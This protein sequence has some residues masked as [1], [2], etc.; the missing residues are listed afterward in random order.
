MYDIE[1][2]SF[3]LVEEMLKFKNYYNIF[4]IIVIIRVKIIK[5]IINSLIMK[6]GVWV[7]SRKGNNYVYLNINN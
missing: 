3:L 2:L 1:K 5:M 6:F 7:I 4:N